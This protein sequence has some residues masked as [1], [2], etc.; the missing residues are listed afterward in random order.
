VDDVHRLL[1]RWPIEGRLVARILR[2]GALRDVEVS[3]REARG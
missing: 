3:P 2:D 1:N